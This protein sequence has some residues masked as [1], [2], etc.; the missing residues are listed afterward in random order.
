MNY[1]MLISR[2]EDFVTKYMHEHVNPALLFHNISH[3]QSVVSITR[4]LA[5]HYELNDKEFFIVVAA[6]W[7]L[8]S[9]YCIDV[10][11]PEQTATELLGTCFNNSGVDGETIQSIKG[12]ILAIKI[13]QHPQSRLEEIICDA[14]S[15]HMGMEDFQKYNAL[16]RK[17]IELLSNTTI[18]KSDWRKITIQLLENHVY[19][20]DYCKE[21]FDKSKADNLEQLKQK[22][23]LKDSSLNG[24][25]SLPEEQAAPAGKS[26]K[27]KKIKADSPDRSIETMFRTTAGTS[28]RL[29]SQ[30]DTKAHIMISVNAII[31]SV[32]LSIVVRR[33]DEFARFMIPVTMLLFVNLVTIILS[34]LAT[35]PNV[36]NGIIDQ[37][38]LKQNKINLLFFGNFLRMNFDEYCDSM[39]GV[40]KDKQILYVT[41]LRNLYEHGIVLGKKYRMLKAAYNVF[42]YGF[43]ISVI[44]FLIASGYYSGKK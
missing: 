7:F 31:I 14:N 42:M 4:Q 10:L 21:Y 22:D 20:T 13:P 18:S 32:L 27:K 41:M 43:V 40:M 1:E 8:N 33:I 23:L 6:A 3:T 37:N 30:A 38:D 26:K 25:T 9:G 36:S 24:V 35:R 29:S 39:L 19:Y 16:R 15:F 11:N 44:V 5:K 2:A 34:I 12:C 28:Q 17:E